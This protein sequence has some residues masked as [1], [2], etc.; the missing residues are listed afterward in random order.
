VA[1]ALQ[2]LRQRSEPEREAEHLSSV[3]DAEGLK[4]RGGRELAIRGDCQA[5]DVVDRAKRRAV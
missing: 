2:D 5:A 3:I 4:T 1:R